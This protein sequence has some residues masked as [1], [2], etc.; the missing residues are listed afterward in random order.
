MRFCRL[1][2]GNAGCDEFVADVFGSIRGL[3]VFGI[4]EFRAF[5]MNG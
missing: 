1:C 3:G 5:G 2:Q 4:P